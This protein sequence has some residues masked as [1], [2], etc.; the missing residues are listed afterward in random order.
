MNKY[1]IELKSFKHFKAFSE[2]TI[3]FT[4]KLAIN[5]K[6]VGHADNRGQGG[7]TNASLS[8]DCGIKVDYSEL[9]DLV[10][11]L[12]SKELVKKETEK[13][14]KKIKKQLAKD[15]VFTRRGYEYKGRFFVFKNGN[16]DPETAKRVRDK[17]AKEGIVDKILNDLPIEEAL[18]VMVK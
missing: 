10:D 6:V 5:G 17:I 11:D 7:S 15:I 12:V 9:S 16:K 1:N 13:L 4:A 8:T 2:E 14:T 3:A 18:E